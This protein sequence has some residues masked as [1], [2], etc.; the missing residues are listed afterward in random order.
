MK[1]ALILVL[2]LALCVSVLAGCGQK[3]EE[4][5]EVNTEVQKNKEAV[6]IYI[7]VPILTCDCVAN[8]ELQNTSQIIK[9]CWDKFAAQYDKYDVSLRS[10]TVYNFEQT[11][12]KENIPDTYGTSDCPDLTFG[13]YFAIS[14][15]INDGHVIPLDDIITDKIRSDFSE[16]TWAQSKGTNGKTY[17]MPYYA[18]QN[19]LCY[20]KDLFTQCGL[21]AFIAEEDV[22]Q[23]WSIDEWETVLST[24][25]EKLP[26]YHYPMMMY[27]KNEQGDTHT[28]VL[29]RAMGSS[30]F[31]ENGLFN[32]STPEGI[33]G[34]Q[35]LKD[36]YDKGY[37]PL[38]C[39]E[40]EIADNTELFM[41]GQIAIYVWNSALATSMEGLN[42]GYVNFP[43]STEGGANSNWITGFMAFDNGD[44]KKIEVVKDFIKFI[45]ETPELLDL[46]SCGQPCSISVSARWADKLIMGVQLAENEKYAVNFTA[47]NPGWSDIRK[48]FWPH[49]QALL[50]GTETAA[51]AA[52]GIDDDCNGVINSVTKS[53]HE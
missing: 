32:L 46:S 18:L 31:D 25:A 41:N 14:G 5:V 30:F 1:K 3:T 45:Y 43:S 44:S 6:E 16:A 39:E 53:L 17:L 52:K 15:Y 22:I 29:L 10:G 4:A 49:I 28:M 23:S 36:N 51:E 20:N 24:L 37:Y 12:Y 26:E 33:A 48:V 42:L 2:T 47:N 34:L 11:K 9:Y 19:V 21:D 27:A 7:N 8:P 38:G 40:M 50:A 35:W 13:G